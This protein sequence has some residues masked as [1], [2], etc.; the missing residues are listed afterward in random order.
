[1]DDLDDLLA[2]LA[3]DAPPVSRSIAGDD[4]HDVKSV[5]ETGLHVG[6]SCDGPPICHSALAIDEESQDDKKVLDIAD[7]ASDVHISHSATAAGE[8]RQ[9]GIAT[10]VSSLSVD[11]ALPEVRASAIGNQTCDEGNIDDLLN[12][13][14]DADSVPEVPKGKSRVVSS[15]PDHAFVNLH[16]LSCDHEV[17]RVE[18]CEWSSKVEYMFLRN[19]YPNVPRLMPQL[20]EAPGMAAYCC[21]CSWRSCAAAVP[22][23][24]VD[25]QDGGGNP[26][27]GIRW[28]SVGLRSV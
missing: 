17:L 25:I 16:C 21:Q 26:T 11:A 24:E 8:A 5:K 19:Y 12:E 2:E 14:L 3:C 18:G 10:E 1:M 7:F 23:T 20:I 4:K 27:S 9:A 28:R 6:L 13:V 15:R 22:I